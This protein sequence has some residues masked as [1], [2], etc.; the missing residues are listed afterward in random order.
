MKMWFAGLALILCSACAFGD[1]IGPSTGCANSVCLGASYTLHVLSYS[2]NQ[3]TVDYVIDGRG[4]TNGTG[5]VI[6]GKT[7]GV[8]SLALNLSVPVTAAT[9]LSAPG[10]VSDWGAQTGGEN[11]SG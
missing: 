1:T 5:S 8:Y 11:S 4:F 2:G 6:T 10:G 9:L 7:A 3:L